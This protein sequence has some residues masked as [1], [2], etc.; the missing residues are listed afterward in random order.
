MSES[1]QIG[2]GDA[3]LI[4]DV[5]TD[6]LPGGALAVPGGDQVVPVINRC[7]E[8]FRKRRLPIFATRDWHPP[9][10]CSFDSEGGAWPR[11]C[12]AGSDGAGFARGLRLPPESEVIDK[13]TEKDEESYSGFEGTGL[14]DILTRAGVTRLFVGG[15]ATDYCVKHTVLAALELGFEALVMRDAVRAVDLNPGDGEAALEEMRQRGARLI[16]ADGLA[17]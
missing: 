2:D 3:L 11:H 16:R 4:V 15:L 17:A 9:D 12:V 13:D 8:L 14:A 7:I 5:Q 6:F 1:N 10:H